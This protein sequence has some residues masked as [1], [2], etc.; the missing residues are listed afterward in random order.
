MIERG[1]N[2]QDLD[3][4]LQ[5]VSSVIAHSNGDVVF[6]SRNGIG[7]AVDPDTNRIVTLLQPGMVPTMNQMRLLAVERGMQHQ[8][9]QR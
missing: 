1:Y 3:A 5:K 4:A 8:A 9:Q 7:V 6:V 2:F